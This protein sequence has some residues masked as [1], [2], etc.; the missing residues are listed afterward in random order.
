MYYDAEQHRFMRY[1]ASPILLFAVACVSPR[2]TVPTS[3]T[4]FIAPTVRS[5]YIESDLARA[6]VAEFDRHLRLGIDMVQVGADDEADFVLQPAVSFAAVEVTESE[7]HGD[8]LSVS[9]NETLIASVTLTA[10]ADPTNPVVVPV[11]KSAQDCG[12]SSSRI[13]LPMLLRSLNGCRVDPL[14]GAVTT[15]DGSPAW[16]PGIAYVEG[17]TDSLWKGLGLPTK[18]VPLLWLDLVLMEDPGDAGLLPLRRMLTIRS[19]IDNGGPGNEFASWL[20]LRVVLLALA[21]RERLRDETLDEADR[22]LLASLL[23]RVAHNVGKNGPWQQNWEPA[24]YAELCRWLVARMRDDHDA[25]R[26]GYRQLLAAGIEPAF[27]KAIHERWPPN[28]NVFRN[29]YSR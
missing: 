20:R 18:R 29:A 28:P 15:A 9:W 5:P 21:A 7:F 3:S 12:T 17:R 4:I 23:D 14:T 25:F 13:P 26:A 1:F 6:I 27:C 10:R 22:R 19:A 16:M 24:S 8:F 2:T 11:L